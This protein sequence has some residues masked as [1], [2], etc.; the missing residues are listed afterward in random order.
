MAEPLYLKGGNDAV[1]L[2]HSY[3][4]DTKDV[5]ELGLFLNQ[6]DYTCYAPVYK[7][8]GEGPETLLNSSPEEWWESAKNGY[9]FLVDEGYE[10]IFIAGISLGGI[11]TLKACQHFK[12]D[13]AV[14]MSSPKERQTDRLKRHVLRYAARYKKKEDKSESQITSEID[15][16]DRTSGRDFEVFKSFID[17]TVE[18][19]P[20][21]SVPIRFLYGGR[22]EDLYKESAE[23]FY[24]Q[25][26]SSEK[27]VKGYKDS[28]HI[29][30]L[31]QEKESIFKDI[32]HFFNHL[33]VS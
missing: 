24:E 32:M 25:V 12:V 16:I 14:V 22:D 3:T 1:L 26:A 21:I 30:L 18:Y 2:L 29:M 28:R 20:D 27:S 15:M 4:S 10:H 13:G 6:H 11:L 23:Y 8:H 5:R 9:Q 31:D 33:K 7:G 19:L 17:E